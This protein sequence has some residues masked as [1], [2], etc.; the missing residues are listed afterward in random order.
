MRKDKQQAGIG[1]PEI[2][3]SLDELVRRGARQVIEQVIELELAALLEQY[4]NERT[5][6]GKQAVVRNGLCDGFSIKRPKGL[7]LLISAAVM[8]DPE[9]LQRIVAPPRLH[10]YS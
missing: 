9:Q 1:L 6:S 3:M 5:L 10:T 4:A 8:P 2:G 7:V